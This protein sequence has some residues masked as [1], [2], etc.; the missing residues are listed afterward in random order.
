MGCSV[1][2]KK[3]KN[4]FYYFNSVQISEQFT[5]ILT[6]GKAVSP[7]YLRQGGANFE[8][9]FPFSQQAEIM[10]LILLGFDILQPYYIWLK[11][12]LY[13]F[14]SVSSFL[15]HCHN[16]CNNTTLQNMCSLLHSLFIVGPK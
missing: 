15:A 6:S 8:L 7:R 4:T 5:Y 13:I 2:D 16:F 14:C 10:Q 9:Y 12:F 3:F 11:Q 1:T